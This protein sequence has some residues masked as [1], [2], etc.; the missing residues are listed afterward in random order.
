MKKSNTSSGEDLM[1]KIASGM[2]AEVVTWKTISET[3]KYNITFTRIVDT[4]KYITKNEMI[5][6]K[7][8]NK[9]Y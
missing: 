1:N 3:I 7:E 5:R 8:K 6:L 9:V 2:D 4:S